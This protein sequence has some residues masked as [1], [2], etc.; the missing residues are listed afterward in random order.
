MQPWW[1]L[2][3]C[4]PAAIVLAIAGL[5]AAALAAMRVKRR[6]DGLK[7]TPLLGYPAEFEA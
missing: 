1:I 4:I 5:I 3:V 7:K 2:A 6:V